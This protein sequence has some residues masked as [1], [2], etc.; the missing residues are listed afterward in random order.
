VVFVAIEPTL[1]V[2]ALGHDPQ[3][4]TMTGDTGQENPPSMACEQ[5]G[6]RRGGHWI[7][8]CR[9]PYRRYERSVV[10]SSPRSPGFMRMEKQRG[11]DSAGVA[12]MNENRLTR[13][14]FPRCLGRP[15]PRSL[16]AFALLGLVTTLATAWIPLVDLFEPL[17]FYRPSWVALRQDAFEAP[18]DTSGRQWGPRSGGRHRRASTGHI[19]A[20]FP[21]R[22]LRCS[23]DYEYPDCWAGYALGRHEVHGGLLAFHQATS[24][25]R[26]GNHVVP[27]T[28][29]WPGLIVDTLCWMAFWLAVAHPRVPVRWWI[30]RR[31]RRRERC[32][33]CAHSLHGVAHLRCPE[34]GVETS[35]S[36]C[37]GLPIRA[38][39]PAAVS[40]GLLIGVGI[41]IGDKVLSVEPLPALHR[42]VIDDD[43][44]AARHLIRS[45]IDVNGTMPPGFDSTAT[46]TPLQ[47]AAFHARPE[48][49]RMLI[50]TGADPEAGDQSVDTPLAIAVQARRPEIVRL[51]LEYGADPNNRPPGSYTPLDHAAKAADPEILALLLRAG[52]LNHPIP[53]RSPAVLEL[54]LQSPEFRTCLQIFL[55][56]GVDPDHF[57][58]HSQPLLVQAVSAGNVDACRAL[59]RAGASIRI[60]DD[61]GNNLW[62][63][64]TDRD[65]FAVARFLV[66]QGALDL[67]EQ[68]N[69]DGRSPL[70]DYR[71]GQPSPAGVF[72]RSYRLMKAEEPR[73]T[74]RAAGPA[75]LGAG[76]PE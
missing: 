23:I 75:P 46:L 67:I 49:V 22:A 13:L 55:D 12:R 58:P 33:F 17:W 8:W 32:A 9:P 31:R 3:P 65:G 2:V 66:E 41:Y 21:L 52:A 20:G 36:I 15:T 60:L 70:D 76:P 38:R 39:W 53:A 68:P 18:T 63:Y 62:H 64:L 47:I 40:V 7:L 54:D 59:L 26:G 29:I 51:L 35:R 73:V 11:T 43:A 48:V 19:A 34:C 24:S 25:V 16:A 57:V 30:R 37:A 27:T 6:P 61:E 1:A 69:H 72:C 14:H 74:R 10:V 5:R 44:D 71:S 42:A 45:G 50:D 28:A 56:W 4:T